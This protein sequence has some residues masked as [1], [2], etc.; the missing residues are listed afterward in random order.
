MRTIDSFGYEVFDLDTH[1]EVMMPGEVP[2]SLSSYLHV[3]RLK[4]E[5]IVEEGLF[6]EPLSVLRLDIGKSYRFNEIGSRIWDLIREPLSVGE[7]VNK[8]LFEYDID[9]MTCETEV[10]GFL[11]KLSKERLIQFSLSC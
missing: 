10:F 11:A 7:V 4:K 3:I 5:Q 8:L 6:G 1:A 9:R 2:Y